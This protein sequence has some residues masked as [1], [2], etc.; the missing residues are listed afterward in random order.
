MIL[1][2]NDSNF[3]E[4]AFYLVETAQQNTLSKTEK[5]AFTEIQV[6]EESG[7]SKTVGTIL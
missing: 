2:A 6:E 3:E 7:D 4:F 1:I 5:G